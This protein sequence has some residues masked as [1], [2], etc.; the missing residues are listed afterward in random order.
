MNRTTI[1]WSV[2]GVVLL[3]ELVLA[4][5]LVPRG[6]SNRTPQAV[7]KELNG[8]FSAYNDLRQQAAKGSPS[9]PFNVE[10]PDDRKRLNEFMPAASWQAV[11][12]AAV[13]QY[14]AQ[15]DAIRGHLIA[16]SQPL[17]RPVLENA[18]QI[19]W[20]RAYEQETARL[21]ADLREAGVITCPPGNDAPRTNVEV[22]TALGL[23][24]HVEGAFQSEEDQVRLTWQLRLLRQV[25]DALSNVKADVLAPP[26]A[27]RREEIALS[28][29]RPQL[30]LVEWTDGN[31]A[32]VRRA[33]AEAGLF[34]RH[35]EPRRVTLVIRGP[36]SVLLASAAVFERNAQRNDVPLVIVLGA[37]L[38]RLAEYA[39]GSR[40]DVPAE[41]G[42]L[43]L[44]LAAL[45]FSRAPAQEPVVAAGAPK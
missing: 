17:H 5:V 4:F 23:Y 8:V 35:V 31:A 28:A 6:S 30:A 43:K 25:A 19:E 3:V 7:A 1:I 40:K 18:N 37:S 36:V 27:E 21:V 38:G 14:T 9:G 20:Y 33:P 45:D 26:T 39:K 2:L 42:E 11:L 15:I 32:A 41:T 24:T 22:R 29:Q 12:Q 10:N 16:R 13:N 34:W 44:Q